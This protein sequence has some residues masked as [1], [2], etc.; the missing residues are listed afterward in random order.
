MSYT[1]RTSS[2]NRDVQETTS[3]QAGDTVVLK[4]GG[5]A[6]TVQARSQNL[7]YCSW[8]EGDKL[9][10]GTFAVDT[11]QADAIASAAAALREAATAIHRVQDLSGD[12]GRPPETP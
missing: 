12:N 4:S 9:H 7:A 1:Q 6:M 8:F 3:P 11:L 2:D 10:H 5:P